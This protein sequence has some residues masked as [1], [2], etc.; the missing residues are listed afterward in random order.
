MEALAR[1]R[2]FVAE[3]KSLPKCGTWQTVL[4]ELA[5]AETEEARYRRREGAAVR[6]KEGSQGRQDGDAAAGGSTSS[7]SGGGGGINKTRVAM[8]GDA[9]ATCLMYMAH[10]LRWKEALG[11]L[12]HIRAFGVTPCVKSVSAALNACGQA[13]EW[14]R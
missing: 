1:S 2:A 3:I 7:S 10:S 5:K 9:Y 13:G 12:D 8:A 6:G 11:I 4:R 14:E